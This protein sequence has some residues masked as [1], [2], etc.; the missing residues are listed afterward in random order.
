MIKSHPKPSDLKNIT[1]SKAI[2]WISQTD[3]TMHG[4]FMYLHGPYLHNTNAQPRAECQCPVLC[5]AE[6]VGDM[7]SCPINYGIVCFVF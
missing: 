6:R 3:M 7:I 1:A 4:M 2:V 5:L